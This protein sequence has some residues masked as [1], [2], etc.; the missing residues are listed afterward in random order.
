MA[1]IPWKKKQQKGTDLV[2]KLDTISTNRIARQSFNQLDC[3]L[4]AES[5]LIPYSLP[6]MLVFVMRFNKIL[7]LN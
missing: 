6:E 1:A 4:R 2:K 7:D 3:F 5:C